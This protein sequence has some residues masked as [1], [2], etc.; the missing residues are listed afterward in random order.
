[1][2]IGLGDEDGRHDPMYRVGWRSCY[3]ESNKRRKRKR[4]KGKKERVKRRKGQK[5]AK[6]RKVLAPKR[7]ER[8]SH[9]DKTHSTHACPRH[10]QEHIYNINELALVQS[11]SE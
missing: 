6:G 5:V 10:M 3:E 2:V 9:D 11:I 1:M 7:E 8:P 4:V